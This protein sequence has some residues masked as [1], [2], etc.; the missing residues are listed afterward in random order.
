MLAE[1]L[2]NEKALKIFLVNFYKEISKEHCSLIEDYVIHCLKEKRVSAKEFCIVLMEVFEEIKT[3]YCD[4]PFF[5][6]SLINIIRELQHKRL[7]G[8]EDIMK[9]V[10]PTNGE[11]FDYVDL[12][13]EFLAGLQKEGLVHK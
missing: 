2:L 6:S 8:L 7:V 12:F 3:Y 4:M 13:G 1:E 10:K 5:I 11:D 9:A